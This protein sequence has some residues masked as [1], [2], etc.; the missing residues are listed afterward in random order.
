MAGLSRGDVID[1][2][3][4][5]FADRGRSVLRVNGQVVFVQGAVPGDLVRL[6]VNKTKRS[7]AE[8]R[9][10]EVLEASPLRTEPRCSYFGACGGCKWQHVRY[11][12]QLEAKRQ[13]V[14][15]MFLHHGAW[16]RIEVLPTIGCASPYFYRNKM[17]FSFSSE[18][19][20][21]SEEI[22]SGAEFDTG[23]ALGLH[24]PGNYR[25]VLDLHE[26]HLQSELSA[27]LVNGLR[28]F[29][30]SKGWA[31]WNVNDHA[32]YLRHLV[33]RQSARTDDLMVNLVTNGHYPD[34]L[35]TTA[36]YL[37]DH[38]PEVS[39]FV[40]T[41]NTGLAQTSFG[42]ATA[43]VFG[44]GTIRDRIGRFTFELSPNA[45][46]QTN[47]SQAERLYEA[48]RAAGSFQ[49][50]DLV[51]DLYSGVGSI[52]LFISDHVARVVGIELVPEAVENA[53]ANAAANGVS[54]C[55]FEVGD[56]LRVFK[57]EFVRTH[58]KPDALVIDPPRAG[59]H[60]R[61]VEQVARLL[62]LRIIYVSCNPATQVRDLVM[63]APYYHVESVQPVDLFP[64]TNHIESVAG[65]RLKARG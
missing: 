41:I 36:A 15:E 62:P 49:E 23:F 5:K 53:R 37:S 58:G 32:G 43:T 9:V 20:L 50:G 40:N 56:M 47:T 27:R 26:C 1:A 54:N 52:A 11:E 13:S 61:V 59:M 63:L 25:K 16:E 55:T 35:E 8:G 33:I 48:A 22:A 51:Y 24:V 19:W 14:E 57:P 21:T 3:V 30:K 7:F 45:F 44:P 12:A 18:R 10:L 29:F 4:E 28:V 2:R 34:R 6:R 39:T 17:E 60:P 46:F 31:P 42:E 65:L 38:F 64:H